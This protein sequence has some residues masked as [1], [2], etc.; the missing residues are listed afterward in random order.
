MSNECAYGTCGRKSHRAGFCVTHYRR[1]LRG[2]DMDRPIREIGNP[3]PLFW[4]NVRKTDGCWEW[5]GSKDRKGYGRFGKNLAH[6]LSFQ[7]THG[8]IP[9]GLL[10]DHT[11][12]NHA[13]VNPGHLRLATNALNAQN[14]VGA[15]RSSKSGVRGVYW[16][17]RA[18]AWRAAATSSGE[19]VNLGTHATVEEA[20]QVVTEWRRCNMPYSLMDQESRGA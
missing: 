5:C 13:C 12:W 6:R 15:P 16:D 2:K 18:K 14:R 4:I 20:E 10:I 8:A 19:R 17:A 11:C 9:K 1:H 3:Q 7:F